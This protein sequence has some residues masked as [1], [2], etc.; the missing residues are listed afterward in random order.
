MTEL[1]ET[2]LYIISCADTHVKARYI[3][4]T[5]D[6]DKCIV[7][8]SDKYDTGSNAKSKLYKYVRNHG[9]WDNWDMTIIGTF[10]NRDEALIAKEGLLDQYNFDLNS[11]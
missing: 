9:G 2:H 8:K 7:Y 10:N 11:R 3:G 1:I 6:W 5:T 4:Y